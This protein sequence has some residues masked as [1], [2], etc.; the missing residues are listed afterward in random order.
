MFST[1]AIF[2]P[3]RSGQ[4]SYSHGAE[5]SQKIGKGGYRL[6]KVLIHPSYIVGILVRLSTVPHTDMLAYL[7]PSLTDS[8]CCSRYV[9][10]P[11]KH[12]DSSG[13]FIEEWH[14]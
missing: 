2:E 11:L 4:L 12:K 1:N 3:D 14:D 5:S 9:V 13:V 10:K 7:Q 6:S 8:K